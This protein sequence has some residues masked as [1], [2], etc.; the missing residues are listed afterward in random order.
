M[1]PG[2][3]L[4][5]GWDRGDG[6]IGLEV[7]GFLMEQAANS[8]HLTADPNSLALTARPKRCVEAPA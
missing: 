3:Q 4:T 8:Q 5:V 1:T 6:A 2:V 7:S